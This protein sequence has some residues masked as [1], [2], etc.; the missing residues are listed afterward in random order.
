ME[1]NIN[2]LKCPETQESNFR[3]GMA[4]NYRSPYGKRAEY[5]RE[6]IISEKNLLS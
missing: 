3:P 4:F 1:E 2:Y 5:L 6:K